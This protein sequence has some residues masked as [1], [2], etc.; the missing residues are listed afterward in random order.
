MF[1]LQPAAA[2]VREALTAWRW[3]PLDGK[4]PFA[5]TALGDVFLSAEHGIWFLDRIAGTL[6]L[7]AESEEALQV[8]LNTENGQEHYLWYA[9]IEAAKQQGIELGEDECYDFKQ[10]PRLGGELSVDNLHSVDFGTA[11]HVA[12]QMH[13]QVKDLAPDTVVDNIE[14]K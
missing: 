9:L 14:I 6:E 4:S 3:L 1:F 12:G 10:A 8:M 7:V 13:E 2:Q 11:L 5:V